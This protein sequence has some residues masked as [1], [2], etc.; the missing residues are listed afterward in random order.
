MQRLVGI[1]RIEADLDE[2]LGRL[3]EL[4]RA[5][6]R[7]VRATGG[8]AYNP[9]WNLVF[10]LRQPADRLRGDRPQRPPADREPRRPQPARLT[11]PPTRRRWGGVNSVVV[12]RRRRHDGASTTTPL[13][14]MPDELRGL[15]GPA[16]TDGGGTDAGRPP[17]GLPRQPRRGGPL[18]RVRRA[19]RGGDGRPRRPPLDPGPRG[20]RP[21]RPLELQGRQ[22]RLVQ[23]RGR[24]PAAA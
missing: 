6:A 3:A 21:R 19:G 15:L 13:P 17:A 7:R 18:R 23:R 14:A 10:E 1:F 16:A 20:A 2:A 5:L 12:A 8:R 22:V 9:G 11:R 4:R 24:R